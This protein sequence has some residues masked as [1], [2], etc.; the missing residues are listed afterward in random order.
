MKKIK[1]TLI[2]SILIWLIM[3]SCSGEKTPA[4]YVDPFIGTD[5]HGHTYPGATTPF[6]AVQLSPDTRRNNWDAASGYHYSDSTLLGFSHLHLSGTGVG[7]LGDILFHPTIADVK[8]KPEGYIFEPHPFSHINEE[9][10]PGYY[11]VFLHE[12]KITAE[13]TA[14]SRVGVHRYTF[15]E[16]TSAKI[17]ID[18]WHSVNDEDINHL[19]FNVT[20][21]DEITGIRVSSGWTPNQHIHFVAKFSKPFKDV[22]LVSAGEIQQNNQQLTGDNIQAILEFETSRNEQIEVNVGTSVVSIEN[23]RLNLEAEANEINFDATLAQTRQIWNDALSVITI[24]GAT[25][26]QK[27]TFYTALYHTLIVPNVV[28]DVN[29]EYRSHNMTIK[30]APQGRRMYST[31][32]LWDTFRTWHPLM[33]LIN[34]QL[35]EDIV[36]SMMSMYEDTGELPIWP[37]VSGETGTMIGYHSVS[38]IWDAYQKGITGFDAEAAFEAMKVSSMSHRKGGKYYVENGF[39]PSNSHKESVSCLLEYAYDDWCISQMAKELGREDNHQYYAGRAASWLNVFDGQTLFFRGK[40]V[41]GNWDPQFNPFEA[42]KHYTEAN[43]WQYRFFVPHDNFGLM[44]QFGSLEAFIEALDGL[45]T[46][47][48]AVLTDI[49]DI[50][51]LIGQYAHGNEPSHHK[52]YIYNYVGQPWKTQEWVRYI[53]ANKY[54]DQPDGIVGNE[55]CGQMSAWY[56]MSSLGIYPVTPGS[57]EYVITS[58]LFE[59][60]TINLYN[61]NTLTITSNNPAQNTYIENVSWN[62]SD[63]SAN[64]VNHADLMQ[65]G[66]L[67]FTLSS[68]PVMTRGTELTDA[69]YSMTQQPRVAVPYITND[70]YLFKEDV[71]IEMGTATPDARIYYTLDGSEPSETS[72]V[73]TQPFKVDRNVT[74]KAKAYKE[75]MAESPVMSV[76]A[77]KANYRNPD[78]ESATTNGVNYRFFKG[79]FAY[80]SEMFATPVISYGVMDEPDISMAG[81]TDDFAF[82]FT[83]L[84]YIDEDGLYDFYTESDDGSMLFIGNQPVVENDGSHGVIRATG[85]IALKKGYH[86][87]RLLYFEDYAGQKLEWGW[88]NIESNK[89]LTK[90]DKNKLFLP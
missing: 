62:G 60:A 81:D 13:L 35:V 73:Y 10:S 78:R 20:G 38:V 82:E 75:G 3:A 25:R 27:R 58:P 30:K 67:A 28:S 47:E 1:S 45:F 8:L 79:K 69:P 29:G 52:A 50:T 87:Y 51:G 64:F 42:S 59:K 15:P 68:Q 71:T 89:P 6:G 39:I 80:T 24:D 5:F 36:F 86:N 55:D 57:G 26:E 21:P 88:K 22:K 33:T 56:V 61:G 31:L 70:L 44:N 49:P 66:T 37:L 53:L 43:A 18:L 23:A 74:I 48:S 32:S 40:R 72:T 2:Y 14:T 11:K 19:E 34:D 16:S 54:S 63:V 77:V 84:L 9:A 90:A 85:R 41:D 46:E 76:N 17:I 83:G 4:D 12:Q 7:D 65:G